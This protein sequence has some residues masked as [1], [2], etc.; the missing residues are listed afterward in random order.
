M[1]PE[2]S[3][4]HRAV[5]ARERLLKYFNNLLVFSTNCHEVERNPEWL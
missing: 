3:T 2:L 4:T 5:T 1:L